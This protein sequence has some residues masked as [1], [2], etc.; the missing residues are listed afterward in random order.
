MI[1]GKILC[2]ISTKNR[3][4]TT[5]PLAISAVI[6][7]TQPPD[8]LVIFDDND[9]PKDM[10]KENVYTNLFQI[11]DM[12]GIAWEWLWA[13][14]KGQHHNHQMSNTMG[15]EWVWR[16]D[17]D[18]IPEPNVLENLR[19]H[20]DNTVGAV[21]G[22]VCTP[23]WNLQP[24]ECTGLIKNIYTEPNPQWFPIAEI[25]QVE[26]LH[27]TFLYRAGIADYNLGLS[28]V[29]HR[30]E[31]LFT[32]E[33]H[34]RG[35]KLLIVPDATTYHLKSPT[36]GILDTNLVELFDRDEKIFQNT[37][38]MQDQTI[39][40][41][42]NGMG[43]HIMFKPVLKDIKNPVVFSCYPEIIPGRS[44]QEAK[45]LFGDIE[46]W[47]IYRKMDQW[48]WTQSVES[49]FRKLYRV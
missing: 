32:W 12:K 28:R 8:K 15:Y 49:A 43:D 21:G 38:G 45:D 29:A 10:R 22:T 19:K 31:T 11:M 46:Q 42:N 13:G 37:I 2:S 39:V 30:E 1:N 17:D 40:V 47:N 16:V 27:C 20:C 3:Y 35:Y 33:L 6:T 26:H 36:G 34:R 7:Q 24:T 14:K 18:T 48:H 44:I 5:L 25:K 4:F 9:E 41:L 23:S